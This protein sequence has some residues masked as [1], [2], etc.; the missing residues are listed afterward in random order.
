MQDNVW[1]VDGTLSRIFEL[2]FQLEE[3]IF[4]FFLYGGIEFFLPAYKFGFLFLL[5][6]IYKHSLALGHSLWS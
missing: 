2:L 4:D 6:V 1:N 5:R 3:T